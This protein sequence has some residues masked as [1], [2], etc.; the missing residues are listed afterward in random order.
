MT[1][2][3]TILRNTSLAAVLALG[4]VSLAACGEDAGASSDGKKVIGVSVAD[5]K[6]LFYVAEVAGIKDEAA[7]QGYEVKIVSANNDS[8]AQVKQ[9]NDLLTQQIGALIFTSQDSTAAAAGVRAANQA[10][11]PVIAVDQRPEEGAGDLAT[12]IATDSV[13]AAYELCTWMFE[14][15]GGEGEIAILH[16]V[17]GSTAEIQRTEGCEKALAENP[18]IEVVAEET[19]NWDETEAFKATQNILTAN[20]NLAAVFGESDAMAMGAS[21]AAKDAGKEIFSV[22]IDGFPTMFDAV[23]AGLTQATMAQQ[24]YMMGQLAVQNAIALLEGNGDDIPAEQY[25]DTVL[26]NAETVGD[27]KV[28]DFYG[29]DAQSFK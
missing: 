18:D 8:S 5:Q 11:V 4:A 20:P 2:H 6:S 15:I 22:G 26:I 17:L 29:P 28:E 7:K 1:R 19:A 12:Y 10:G 16:G 27:H 3:K 13:K 9:V 23:T 24:P 21:K 25:Q 14:Q